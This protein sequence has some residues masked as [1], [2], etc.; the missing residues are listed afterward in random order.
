MSLSVK[1]VENAPSISV[2]G[3]V[4]ALTIT[5]NVNPIKEH[6]RRVSHKVVVLRRV[7]QLQRTD[8]AT[9]QPDDAHQDGTQNEIIFGIQIIPDLSV[10]IDCTATVHIHIF[11]TELEEGRSVLEALFEGVGLP[12]VCI[13]GE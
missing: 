11:T 8:C 13:V 12:I 1:Q 7:P 10:A 6:I 2:L 4:V 9:I 3:L 5:R